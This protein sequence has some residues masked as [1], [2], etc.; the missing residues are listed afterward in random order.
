MVCEKS[1]YHALTAK[2]G[3]GLI[4]QT[5]SS[6]NARKREQVEEAAAGIAMTIAAWAERANRLHGGVHGG[7]SGEAV[8]HQND[9]LAFDRRRWTIAA[10]VTFAALQLHALAVNHAI[11]GIPRYSEIPDNFVVEYNCAASGNGAHREFLV[12]GNSEFTNYKNI[13]WSIEFTRNLGSNGNPASRQR[14]DEYIAAAAIAR[15]Q[16]FPELPSCIGAIAKLHCAPPI[17]WTFG[18]SGV[19]PESIVRRRAVL[20]E[21]DYR[22]GVL[23]STF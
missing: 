6:T 21:G 13:E 4:R 10:I 15:Q 16:R 12:P 20:Y 2:N 8:V 7:A 17:C 5:I 3:S 18:E 11:D 19:L 1:S 14:Q 22:F 9:G 23:R